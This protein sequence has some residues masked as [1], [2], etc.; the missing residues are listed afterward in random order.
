MSFIAAVRVSLSLFQTLFIAQTFSFDRPLFSTSI[1]ITIK[2]SNSRVL[3][4][5]FVETSITKKKDNLHPE[6]MLIDSYVPSVFLS[7]TFALCIFSHYFD[8]CLIIHNNVVDLHFRLLVWV[9]LSMN[10]ADGLT[11]KL[12]QNEQKIFY[13]YGVT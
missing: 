5:C 1:L 11:M 2:Q 7:H 9:K 3:L 13:V 10:A 12:W 4:I 8:C 6:L